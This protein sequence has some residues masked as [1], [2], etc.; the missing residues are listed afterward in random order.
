M[1]Q[2]ENCAWADHV[3]WDGTHLL[4]LP[5]KIAFLKLC[6]KWQLF[7]HQLSW[8]PCLVTCDKH[9]PFLHH[10]RLSGDWLHCVCVGAPK[11][12]SVPSTVRF[13]SISVFAQQ[14]LYHYLNVLLH[15][16]HF[17]IKMSLRGKSGMKWENSMETY[18]TICKIASGNWLCDTD[19]KPELCDN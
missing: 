17:F 12:G 4:Y 3:P 16:F 7:Q 6:C 13:G 18:I 9:C 19:L 15:F 10:N 2:S 5:F 8:S 14:C 1:C 11:F